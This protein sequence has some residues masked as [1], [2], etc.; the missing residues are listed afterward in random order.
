MIELFFLF[1]LPLEIR[2][3]FN[4]LLHRFFA[5]SLRSFVLFPWNSTTFHYLVSKQSQLIVRL[6]RHVD[7]ISFQ[8]AFSSSAHSF[9]YDFS[10]AKDA[11]NFVVSLMYSFMCCINWSDFFFISIER[12][13]WKR[14]EKEI[15]HYSNKYIN[16][17]I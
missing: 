7:L 6:M 9:P 5:S 17:G 16:R 1:Y 14:I 12:E 2:S 4:F 15:T 10:F 3:L 13:E 8:V 11:S